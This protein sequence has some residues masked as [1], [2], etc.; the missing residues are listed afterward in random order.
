MLELDTLNPDFGRA[1]YY[2]LFLKSSA[3]WSVTYQNTLDPL[4]T[5]SARSAAAN[6]DDLMPLL[7]WIS[8]VTVS[9]RF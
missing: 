4:A 5:A 6:P 2:N 3:D 8:T 7:K 9:V 1:A